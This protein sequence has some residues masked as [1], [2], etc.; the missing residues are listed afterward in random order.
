MP[1]FRVDAPIEH[2]PPQALPLESV[3]INLSIDRTLSISGQLS[4]G[5]VSNGG[6]V[7]AQPL[8]LL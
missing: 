5:G 4:S 1:D 6:T 3:S 8:L 7:R 2:E